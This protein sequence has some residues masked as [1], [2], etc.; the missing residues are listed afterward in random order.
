M[1]AEFKL[2]PHSIFAAIKRAY[3][4]TCQTLRISCVHS[5]NIRVDAVHLTSYITGRRLYLIGHAGFVT[6]RNLPGFFTPPTR[7]W[8]NAGTLV[9]LF[10]RVAYIYIGAKLGDGSLLDSLWCARERVCVTLG[11]GWRRMGQDGIF[12]LVCATASLAKRRI[13]RGKGHTR[14]VNESRISEWERRRV[15]LCQPRARMYKKGT[16]A[17]VQKRK[18]ASERT[19]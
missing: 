10:A 9:L 13:R 6:S 19:N 17:N 11:I 18:R 15:V 4:Y 14:R 3:A 2:T 8:G 1:P 7:G 5:I 12:S 16:E